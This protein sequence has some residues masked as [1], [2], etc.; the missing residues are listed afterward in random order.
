MAKVPGE[1]ELAKYLATV[2][3]QTLYWDDPLEVY[4]EVS[5]V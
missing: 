3:C 2:T 4:G 5:E 1:D